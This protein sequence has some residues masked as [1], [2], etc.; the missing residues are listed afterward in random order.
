MNYKL[1][2]MVVRHNGKIIQLKS[3]KLKVKSC[4][5]SFFTFHYS[6]FTTPSDLLNVGQKIYAIGS[7]M[8]FENTITDG[9]MSSSKFISSFAPLINII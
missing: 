1:D 8:G 3:E 9:I 6:L 4:P 2:K 7:P 5:N